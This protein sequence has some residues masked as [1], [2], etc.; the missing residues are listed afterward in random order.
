M[1]FPAE[2]DCEWWEEL[3]LGT[4]WLC[5]TRGRGTPGDDPFAVL[6]ADTSE[7]DAYFEFC[8]DC[9]SDGSAR[10]EGEGFKVYARR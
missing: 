8:Q 9:V 3:A 4:T 5:W 7:K 2:E 10:V 1:E 6:K